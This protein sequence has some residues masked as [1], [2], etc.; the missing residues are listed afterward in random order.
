[1]V[2]YLYIVLLRRKKE[3]GGEEKKIIPAVVEALREERGKTTLSN[4]LGLFHTFK[5]R[6]SNLHKRG[7]Y[8]MA[9]KKKNK[10][11]KSSEK[12]FIP[13]LGD[14]ENS[15]YDYPSKW[16]RKIK[17]WLATYGVP[18]RYF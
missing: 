4:I 12:L 13:L 9:E 18:T 11:E 1:L 2:S 15:L 3:G 17:G 16:R 8:R 14:T 5:G 6:K 10:G 7:L